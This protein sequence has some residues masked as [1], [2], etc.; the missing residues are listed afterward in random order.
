MRRG[1]EGR[2]EE[3]K[4]QTRQGKGAGTIWHIIPRTGKKG[5]DQEEMWEG[6]LPVSSSQVAP[7]PGQPIH[8]CWDLNA[9][10]WLGQG[11]GLLFRSTYLQVLFTSTYFRLMKKV[12]EK[13]NLQVTDLLFTFCKGKDGRSLHL[14]F[15]AYM[16]GDSEANKGL[17]IPASCFLIQQPWQSYFTFISISFPIYQ[18]QKV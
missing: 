7:S 17:Q 18:M 10:V 5:S 1:E 4:V 11:P 9:P 2:R 6:T 13:T 8:A 16:M 12:L 14:W 15:S 3:R